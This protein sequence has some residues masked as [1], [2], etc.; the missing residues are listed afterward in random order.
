MSS[1]KVF[2]YIFFL[3]IVQTLF[4]QNING[5][6]I[7][8]SKNAMTSME[9]HSE[10]TYHSFVEKNSPYNIATL[11]SKSIMLNS[12]VSV[13]KPYH[14]ILEEGGRKHKFTII[15]KE[16]LDISQQDWDFSDLKQ[17]D[18]EIKDFKP[19]NP[20]S[21]NNAVAINNQSQNILPTIQ[22]ANNTQPVNPAT[23]NSKPTIADAN[24]KLT[25]NK[26]E[27]L[28]AAEKSK[29]NKNYQDAISKYQQV[30]KLDPGNSYAV[31]GIQDVNN[32]IKHET[33][34]QYS[35]II[36]KANNAYA[37]NRYDEA[38]K[39][40]N[41]A[42]AVQPDDE[43]A[44]NQF[45]L[46][47]KKQASAKIEEANRQKDSLFIN[48]INAGDKALLNKSYDE[49]SIN[50]NEALKI[51]P[52]DSFA[53]SKVA[54]AKQKKYDDSVYA[55]QTASKALYTSF[56]KTGDK[57]MKEKSYN[58]A[59]LAYNKAMQVKPNDA[60]TI[61]KISSIDKQM[62]A[63]SV[64]A[65]RS[66]NQGLHDAFIKSG[67][68]AFKQKSY[69][70]AKSDYN[71]ALKLISDDKHATGQI[72]NID[73]AIEGIKIQQQ[74]DLEIQKDI[75]QQKKF[76]DLITNADNYYNS[77]M[78]AEAKN[79]YAEALSLNSKDTYSKN[80]ISN[81]N[82]IFAHQQE[83]QKEDSLNSIKY[84]ALILKADKDFD[85]KNYTGAQTGYQTALKL[86]SEDQYTKDKLTQIQTS[87]QEMVAR[88]Q[89]IKD[90]ITKVAAVSK[91]YNE[92][93]LKAKAAYSKNDYVMSRGFYTAA[94]SLKPAEAE[95]KNQ[96]AD[97]DSKLSAIAV[98]QKQ[99]DDYDSVSTLGA[100]ALIDSD[101]NGAIHQFTQ[102][103]TYNQQDDGY[104]NKQIKYAKYQLTLKDSLSSLATKTEIQHKNVDSVMMLYTK[105]KNDLKVLDYQNAI[106]DFQQF[107]NGIDYLGSTPG[108]YNFTSLKKFSKSKISDIQAYLAKPKDTTVHRLPDLKNL[109]TYSIITYHNEKDPKL[110]FIYIKY[111]DINFEQSP[112]NQRFDS[113]SDYGQENRLIGK[114]VMSANPTTIAESISNGINLICQN[115]VFIG[116]KVYLKFLIQN[117]NAAEYLTGSMLLTLKTQDGK[118]IQ[119]L[120]NYVAGYPIILPKKEKVIV[121]VTKAKTV[122]DND[123]LIFDLADRL[124]NAKVSVT[125]PGSAYNHSK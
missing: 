16:D 15:Y 118:A 44:K 46:I 78:Y 83:K 27:L 35:N 98:L 102:V 50:Y 125:I 90:S 49:A 65:E 108:P 23:V 63:D 81:I 5:F 89:S 72:K 17:L 115:V 116:S 123:S 56:I 66:K 48:Y 38:L 73:N 74:K 113:I 100:T 91:E 21:Q 7:Y 13:D 76:T 69:D 25:D 67:D 10:V 71:E 3:F 82:D 121:Y 37:D 58:E 30:L 77:G 68:D 105:G 19:S 114:E 26:Y 117:T 87:M 51:K 52:D 20:S 96:I 1:K 110:N 55:V 94:N 62:V 88:N 80:K 53:K 59:R 57:A 61:S 122:S 41:D 47:Q 9:F 36:L 11:D 42:L 101:Y 64:L 109:P 103:L 40:Y 33:G 97:I 43:Y 84:T 28:D 8:I 93:I 85:N 60:S 104:A 75:E 54:T 112:D 34:Q 124:S 106:L 79:K 18:N 107:V 39:Y 111:P 92:I 120:P 32:L 95:P 70:V 31:T 14:L 6:E 86:K 45:E 119:M 2:F 24:N 22:N 4:A 29:N 99:K 12:T